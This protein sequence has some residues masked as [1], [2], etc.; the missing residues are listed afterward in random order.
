MK[1]PLKTE[2]KTNSIIQTTEDYVGRHGHLPGISGPAT[3]SRAYMEL[4][5]ADLATR[6]ELK[7]RYEEEGGAELEKAWR[8]MNSVRRKQMSAKVDLVCP[9]CH[10][11][12][13]TTDEP[14]NAPIYATCPYCH[15]TFGR[16]EN[17]R[18]H[19]DHPHK[20]GL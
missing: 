3:L 1:G 9:G 14:H 2:R 5:D 17:W 15:V 18:S 7:K 20:E 12:I 8:N 4:I 6:E 10:K 16:S 13:Q 11:T 19:L